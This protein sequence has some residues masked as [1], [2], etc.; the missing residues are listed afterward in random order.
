MTRHS[1]FLKIRNLYK[2]QIKLMGWG[3]QSDN[4]IY[5]SKSLQLGDH[6]TTKKNLHIQGVP[7]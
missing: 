2:D 3:R 5:N 7:F 1:I 4:C 6:T